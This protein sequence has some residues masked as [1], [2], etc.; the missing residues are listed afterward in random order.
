MIKVVSGS[1]VDISALATDYEGRTLMCGDPV[2]Y[3][4]DKGYV[5]FGWYLGKSISGKSTYMLTQS[6]SARQIY[7]TLLRHEWKQPTYRHQTG[8]DNY[9][10]A[11]DLI[12]MYSDEARGI[13]NP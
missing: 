6:G 5:I 10:I 3:P 8:V 11:K 12:Q 4:S 13:A 7:Y 9:E 1:K 2:L